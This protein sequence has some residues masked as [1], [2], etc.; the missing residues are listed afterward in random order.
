MADDRSSE[1]IINP[2]LDVGAGFRLRTKAQGGK[3]ERFMIKAHP[4]LCRLLIDLASGDWTTERLMTIPQ[5]L[6]ERLLELGVL[7]DSRDAPPEIYFRCDLSD[8]PLDLV[9]NRARPKLS[10]Q[11]EY[12]GL[13]VNKNVH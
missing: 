12:T 11:R 2:T 5:H 13:A 3:E 6:F 9:P 8:L 1:I 10:R 4:D 7:I